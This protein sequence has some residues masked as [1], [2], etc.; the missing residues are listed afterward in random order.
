MKVSEALRVLARNGRDRAAHFEAR[1]GASETHVLPHR[2]SAARQ[3]AEQDALT[4]RMAAAEVE[5]LA[6]T[7]AK[8]GK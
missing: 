4:F 3:S 1:A 7:L 8:K 6:V 2:D 5:A